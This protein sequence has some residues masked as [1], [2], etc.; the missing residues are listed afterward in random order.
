MCHRR[1]SASGCMLDCSTAM[2]NP[3]AL[4]PVI[5]ES[6]LAVMR[7]G[8]GTGGGGAAG[9]PGGPAGRADVSGGRGLHAVQR[10]AATC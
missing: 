8:E 1:T 6:G 3:L 7:S 9:K 4:V 10:G 2:H 5:Q